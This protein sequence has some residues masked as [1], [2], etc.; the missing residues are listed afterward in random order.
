[1]DEANLKTGYDAEDPKSRFV[2]VFMAASVLT[3][4]L[5]LLGLQAYYDR[6]KE[7]QIYIKQL[8]PVAED[9]R[10][11]RAREE[12]ELHS[13]RYLDRTRG[14]VRLPIE[15]AM[16]LFVREAAGGKF[17]YPT[18]PAPVKPIEPQGDASAKTN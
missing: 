14:T 4:V 2:G 7:Q 18:Q 12:S 11:L 3:L 9:L 13:Y 10:N 1:M 17:A 8:A 6:V 15:R 16:E 5:V